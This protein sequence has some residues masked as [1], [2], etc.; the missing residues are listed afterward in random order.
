MKI[1][2]WEYA[3]GALAAIAILSSATAAQAAC[4][5]VSTAADLQAVHDNL[6]AAYCLE[7]DLDLSSVANFI[8][9]AVGGNAFTGSFDGGGH[10]IRNLKMNRADLDDVG[11]FGQ[12]NGA[13]IKDL[14][15]ENVT[16]ASTR[17]PSFLGALAGH[18]AGAT[19]ISDVH[20]SGQ[21]AVN[22][23]GSTI[24]G[25]VAVLQ[26]TSVIEKSSVSAQVGT[27]DDTNA[28]GLAGE[29]HAG[30][31]I[32]NSYSTGAVFCTDNCDAGGIVGDADVGSTITKSFA[33]GE[34]VCGTV[35]FCGG[36]LGYGNGTFSFLYASGSVLTGTNTATGGLVGQLDSATL[37]QSFSVGLV[38]GSGTPAGGLIGSALNAPTVTNSYWDRQTSHLS[39]SAGG[40]VGR[41]T[42]QLRANMP[43]G[44]N[45]TI[46]GITLKYSYP[47]LKPPQLNFKPALA[48]RVVS[49]LVFAFNPL[50][51]LDAS[52][53]LNPAPHSDQASLAACYTMIARA[54]GDAETVGSLQDVAIDKY[55]WRDASRRTFWRGPVTSYATLGTFTRIGANASLSN[56]VA[57]AMRQGDLVLLHGKYTN[58]GAAAESWMLGTLFTADESGPVL[59]VL[60]NDPVTGL[61]VQISS[62]TKMVVSPSGFPLTNFKVD[63]YTRVTIIP[64]A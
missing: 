55:F 53:Y 4:T 28:G 58:G 22:A 52:N 29:S 64:P 61:Q 1:G 38:G 43:G 10:V 16:V 35:S 27:L 3:A 24:G 51:Q 37:D 41:T 63:G 7:N 5:A 47:Y 54:I 17:V 23:T 20:V 8:P 46:W 40:G 56:T 31:S 21:V 18:A 48:T 39:T 2:T 36:A 15:L 25:L 32:R 45:T 50:S 13:T 11:L 49:T 30:T 6:S 60:A 33:T 59:R 44:F 9:L 19:L 62:S 34:I 42:A 57:P 14:T 12:L 26:D